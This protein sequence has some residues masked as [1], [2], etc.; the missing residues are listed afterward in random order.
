VTAN[1]NPQSASTNLI[2]C[3]ISKSMPL[4]FHFQLESKHTHRP[5]FEHWVSLLLQHQ[6]YIP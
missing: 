5:S 1:W 4:E 2:L 3:W 6:N